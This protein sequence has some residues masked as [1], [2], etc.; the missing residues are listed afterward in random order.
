[1]DTDNFRAVV[2]EILKEALKEI[3]VEE[4]ILQTLTENKKVVSKPAPKIVGQLNR[5]AASEANEKHKKLTES[6]MK[7]RFTAKGFDPFDGTKPLKESQA[8]DAAPNHGP[9]KNI[10][11][12]DPGVDVSSLIGGNKQVWK[13]L[14]TGK[15]K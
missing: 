2:K 9:L 4:G 12:S 10:D 14:V 13:T 7:S 15:K 6:V 8:S 5:E 3:L 1:M 11:P